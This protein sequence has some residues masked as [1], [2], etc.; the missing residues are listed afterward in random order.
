MEN[1]FLSPCWSLFLAVRSVLHGSALAKAE[2]HEPKNL[3]E[4]RPLWYHRSKTKKEWWGAVTRT[5]LLVGPSTQVSED[6]KPSPVLLRAWT[7]L[8]WW[9]RLALRRRSVWDTLP[10]S[11]G[12]TAINWVGTW[13]TKRS[14]YAAQAWQEEKCQGAAAAARL[15]AVGV[16][17]RA[18]QVWTLQIMTKWRLGWW[19]SAVLF[20]SLQCF[21]PNII[22]LHYVFFSLICSYWW[23]AV[24]SAYSCC[25]HGKEGKI[26]FALLVIRDPVSIEAL[27]KGR[28]LLV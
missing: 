18:E 19:K 5:G 7:G 2:Q 26:V 11:E 20:L 23:L 1:F 4:V 21:L 8:G 9:G 16:C 25:R 27:H 12:V 22:W 10:R 13:M 17:D 15:G 3:S 14:R 24:L 6:A 28:K